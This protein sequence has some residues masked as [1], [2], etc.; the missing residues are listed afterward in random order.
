MD[1]NAAADIVA[2]LEQGKC[3]QDLLDNLTVR[4]F[5]KGKTEDIHVDKWVAQQQKGRNPWRLKIWDL[6]DRG[7]PARIIYALDPR[8]SRYHVLGVVSRDFNYDERDDRTKGIL[9]A[10][11]ELGIPD[12]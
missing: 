10:Y 11:D 9:A 2:L 7:V 3:D 4:D 6:E 5:G 12:Y 8:I 1:E